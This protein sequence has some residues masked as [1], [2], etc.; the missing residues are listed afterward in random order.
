MFEIPALD[1]FPQVLILKALNV[2]DLSAVADHDHPDYVMPWKSGLLVRE[3][4]L[5]IVFSPST[6][7]EK[8]KLAAICEIGFY[9]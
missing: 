7:D 6:D 5:A 3:K 8:G 2:Y 9:Q 1:L 4:K